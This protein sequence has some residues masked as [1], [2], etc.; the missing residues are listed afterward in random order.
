MSDRANYILID[1][2]KNLRTYYDKWCLG[3][4]SKWLLSNSEQAISDLRSMQPTPGYL[5]NETWC[6]SAV[7]IDDYNKVLKFFIS[8][9]AISIGNYCWS[10]LI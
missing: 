5:L 1:K 10:T 3:T 4:I 7:L 9:E 6:D 2:K 8:A